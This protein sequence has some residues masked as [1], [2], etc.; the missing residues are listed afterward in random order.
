MSV[1]P[2]SSSIAP[3]S[4]AET[5]STPAGVWRGDQLAR[6]SGTTVSSGFRA[7]DAELPGNG[8]PAGGL[9]ECLM[10]EWGVGEMQLLAPAL[11]TAASELLFIA[12]PYLPCGLSLHHLGI[13]LQRLTVLQAKKAIDSLWAAEQAL[14]SGACGGIVLWTS[15]VSADQLRRLQ[16][17]AQGTPTLMFVMRPT[18]CLMQSSPAPLRLALQAHPGRRLLLDL[19]KRRGPAL[20]RSLILDLPRPLPLK[21]HSS[22]ERI[23]MVGSL[24]AVIDAL[25]RCSSSEFAARSLDSIG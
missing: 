14:K 3:P 1:F 23:R 5:A 11:R 24:K 12:P 18:V 8:W 19:P 17:A 4:I 25:D 7:L 6:P 15:H 9:T 13:N 10:P 22:N 2:F 21:I 16:L 20:E